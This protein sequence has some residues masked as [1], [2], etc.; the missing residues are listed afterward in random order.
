MVH[1]LA[2][3]SYRQLDERANR[4]AH[5]LRALGVG[6]ETP[7]GLCVERSLD[8]VVGLLG[9]LKAGGAY[10]PLDPAYPPER[11][12][13]ILED[14]LRGVAAPVL[15]TQEHL[16]ERFRPE[17][18]ELPFRLVALDADSA[19]LA[20][21]KPRTE[22]LPDLPGQGPDNLAYVIYTSGSTG[23]PKGVLIPH[24][25][26]VRLFTAT[27][28]WF[29]FGPEDVWTIF[30]SYAFDFSVWEIWGAL[31][32]GGR[33][34]VVPREVSLSPPAFYDLLATERVTVLDQTPSAFRQLVQLEEEEELGRCA[35]AE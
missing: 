26:A 5:R 24:A 25:N 28:R 18:R 34:V 7:V 32:H 21:E 9:I 13:W 1:D 16:V 11:L 23:R 22:R 30:H 15:V 20:A 3:L 29:G 4:L 14:A 19:A 12:A 33:L 17:D 31:L 27:D 2:A 6:P 35:C 10:V 8:M